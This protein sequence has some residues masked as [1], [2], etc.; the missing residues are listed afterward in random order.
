MDK[1][2]ERLVNLERK[3][4]AETAIRD[5]EVRIIELRAEVEAEERKIEKYKDGLAEAV[6]Y[7]RG[8]GE[9]TE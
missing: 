1:E 5:A 3:V 8:I 4:M 2:I 7:L 9:D 6:A